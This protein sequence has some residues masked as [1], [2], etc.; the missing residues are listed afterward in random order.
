M[1]HRDGKGISSSGVV[2]FETL[3]G[4]TRT[5]QLSDDCWLK[6]PLKREQDWSN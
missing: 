2:C 4:R 6:V 1:R 3:F 5:V